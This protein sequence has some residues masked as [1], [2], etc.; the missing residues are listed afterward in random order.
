MITRI[1]VLAIL[2]SVFLMLL[3]VEFIRRRQ[4]EGKYAP[5]WLLTCIFFLIGSIN[6]GIIEFLARLIGIVTLANFLLL[7]FFFLVLICLGLTVVASRESQRRRRFAQ[8][9]SLLRFDLEDI[10]RKIGSGG[11]QHFSDLGPSGR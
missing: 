11:A 4:L 2:A 8:E 1:Q 3:T 6:L 5:V 7:A 10:K 9:L